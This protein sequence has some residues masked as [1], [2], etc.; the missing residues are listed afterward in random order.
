MSAKPKQP[1]PPAAA[2]PGR[3]L[4]WLPVA[5]LVLAVGTSTLPQ[6]ASALLSRMDRAGSHEALTSIA[7]D[8]A[9]VQTVRA[10]RR[11]ARFLPETPVAVPGRLRPAT[12][13]VPTARPTAATAPASH[14]ARPRPVPGVPVG[15]R[16]PALHIDV[17]V[18]PIA[19]T[20]GML[21]PP[22]NPQTLGWWEDGARPGAR[23]GSA[24]VTGHTVHT[25]GGA[26]DH[27]ARLRPGD[28]L[29]VSTRRGQIR[30]VVT[31]VH[32]YR[33]A[34]IAEHAAQLFSQNV[35][36]RLVLITCDDWTGSVYLSNTVAIA[37][38]E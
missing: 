18:V 24:L 9:R 23:V 7:V 25:G 34:R 37:V 26:F 17:P 35:S 11:P 32:T 6:P 10:V 21:V 3:R 5:A 13:T 28:S 19:A 20:G 15:L 31:D 4:R 38:P 30:Y 2:V 1:H 8:P 14:P 33:K 29:R 12:G 16:V 36:G 22:S 27:L